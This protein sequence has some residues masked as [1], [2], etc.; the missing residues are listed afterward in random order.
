MKNFYSILV[1]SLVAAMTNNFVWFAVTFWVFLE[2]RSVISTS[3]MA[4]IFTTTVA[5][6]GFFLGSLVDRYPKKKVMLFSS[7]LTLL[8]FALAAA[9][10]IT[11][12][13]Q[14]YGDASS[15]RLWAF[16]VLVLVGA[17]TGN[18]RGIALSTLVTIMIPED[19]RDRANGM[20]GTAMGVSFLAASVSSGLAVGFLG[21]TGMLASALI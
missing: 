5:L 17:I 3:I 13:P 10:F 9:V 21:M 1:N 4:G 7:V 12:P 2:T 11:I 19:T 20:V 6:S 15:L 14:E 8:L 16:I 18:M